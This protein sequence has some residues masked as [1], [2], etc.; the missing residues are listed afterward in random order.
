MAKKILPVSLEETQ[1]DYIK[2]RSENESMAHY[3]RK[4]INEDMKRKKK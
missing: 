3:I 1:Y 4:L 2:K